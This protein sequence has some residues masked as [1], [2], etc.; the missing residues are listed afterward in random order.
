VAG[1]ASGV[2][3][4]GMVGGKSADSLDAVASS[5]IVGA[6]ASVFFPLHCKIQKMACLCLHM[7]G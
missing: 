7:S 3:M 1:R 6:S 2:K 5:Q 4:V